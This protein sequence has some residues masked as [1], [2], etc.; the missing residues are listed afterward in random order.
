MASNTTTT[1][2]KKLLILGCS[3]RKRDTSGQLPAFELYDGMMYRV[4]RKFLRNYE[5]PESLSLATLSAEHALIGGITEIEPYD[6]LM[7]PSRAKDIRKRCISTLASWMDD[8][9]RCYVSA[10]KMY[11]PAID[12]GQR[13]AYIPFEGGIGKKQQQVKQF[14]YE[15]P[16]KPRKRADTERKAA[17]RMRYFLPDWD[18]LLDPD[19]DFAA[20]KFSAPKRSDRNDQ[21]CQSLLMQSSQIQICDGIL[22]SLAQ[23]QTSKGPLR[24]LEG[25]EPS[26]LSPKPLRQ[27][28]GLAQ[29]QSLF[30]DCG[31]FSYIG[32]DEPTIS[33]EQAIALYE[34]Y[35]FDFGT[36]VDHIPIK[37]LSDE[38]RQARVDMTCDNADEFIKSWRKRGKLFTPV[39]AIQG[40]DAKQYGDNVRKYYDM[41]YGHLAIGGLVP[42]KDAAIEEIVRSVV[43]TVKQLPHRPWIH[44]FGIY[45]PK[46]Q[47]LFREL[48][49]DSFDSASYFRKSW[50][51]SDQNYLGS[52]GK[53]YAALRV[54]MTADPRTRKRLTQT[55]GNIEQLERQERRALKMLSEYDAGSA[56]IEAT[57]DA[58]I[59]Y[60]RQ[61]KRS[62]D[63]K[64]MRAKYKRTLEDKPWLNCSCTFCQQLGIQ[65]LIFRGGNRNRR[66][67]AHNT[68]MLY[69]DIGNAK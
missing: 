22:V 60:D 24:K 21:H 32:E 39:G 2:N 18:D 12:S 4:L 54:P 34:L 47:A 30:G 65:I 63:A 68:L 13:N 26:A 62:S 53:W 3:D 57:L 7:T 50:L 5:W 16:S 67:G 33:T 31:A 58:V 52:N 59:E 23:R 61:L 14:L 8:Q 48:G 9:H 10:G 43:K 17:G 42:L 37:T 45:R 46:L 51:R 27:H 64:S 19:F 41:G 25:T 69:K 66:R 6:R 28:F 55:G 44:L 36:S 38:E 1:E 29:N 11:L 20:D 56:G 49:V 40:I 35:N 15:L